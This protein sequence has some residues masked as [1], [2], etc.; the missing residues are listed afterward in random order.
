MMW[1]Y[2][3]IE[4]TTTT[5]LGFNESYTR[6]NP[7]LTGETINPASQCFGITYGRELTNKF[8]FGV[9]TKYATENLVREK[10]S[11]FLFDA[12]LVFRTGFRSLYLAATVRNFG[13]D[14][15]FINE[16]YP[17]PQTFK[18]GV[19][20]YLIAPNNSFLLQSDSQSLLV[21]FDL[22]HPRDYDEQYNVGMEYT[23]M[24][25]LALRTGYN[26]NYDEK[27]LT[28]GIGLMIKDFRLDYAYEPFGKILDSVHK[29][30]FNYSL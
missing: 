29:F 27:S 12:G 9:T 10:K 1:D 19:S 28:F 14:V 2:G 15:T 26:I 3:S 16:S 18:F 6:F 25:M 20:T 23:L 17:L 13:P 7:G 8:S 5:E 30:T 11:T 22:S 4:V 21:S 24:D